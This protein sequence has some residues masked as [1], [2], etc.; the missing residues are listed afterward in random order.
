MLLRNKINNIL[1]AFVSLPLQAGKF[2]GNILVKRAHRERIAT[3]AQRLEGKELNKR[4]V[5]PLWQNLFF[6]RAL[7]ERIA[8][9]ARRLKEIKLNKRVVFPL[10]QNLFVKQARGERIA[11]KARRLKGEERYKRVVYLLLTGVVIISLFYFSLPDILFDSPTSVVIEDEKGNLL[12]AK[13]AADEQWR[14]PH[15]AD[16]PEKFRKALITYE[17]K[18]FYLHNGVDAPSVVRA[19]YQNLIRGKVFSGASTITM[20]TIRLS[21]QNKNRS[22][23]EKIIESVLALR[24]ELT[25]SKKEILALYS[26]NAPFGGNVVG[27]NAAA[28]RYFGRSPDKL[29]WAETATLAV[30]PNN[31]SLV[32]PGKNRSVLKSKRNFLLHELFSEGIID[33]L[34]YKLSLSEEVPVTPQKLPSL[35]PHLLD[36]VYT[37][38]A[39]KVKNKFTRV[40][41]TINSEFQIRANEIL[42]RHYQRLS[43]NGIYNASALI[44]DNHSGNVL[45]YTGNVGNPADK[46][47]GSS[48]DIITSRRSSGSILKPFLFAALMDEGSILPNS[49]IED[50]PTKFGG[51]RPLNFTNDY[52]GAVPAGETLA[53]SLN[54]PAVR[55]LQEY[56]VERFH[57]L[58]KKLG[59]NSLQYS[60]SH[61]GLSLILG[62]AEVT[63]WDIAGI[64]SAMARTL[65]HFHE[66]KEKH[67]RLNEFHPLN[68]ES[69]LKDSAYQ[70][71]ETENA[72]GLTAASVWF[73]FQAL[74]EA[75]RPSEEGSWLYFESSKTIAWKTGT[76]Q[77]FRD[78]WSVGCT[79]DFTVAV[80][81]GNADGE[82]R[83]L[84]TGVSAAA[85]I[86]FDLFDFLPVT[87]KW[88]DEPVEEMT[89]EEICVQSGYRAGENC[90]EKIR[91]LIPRTGLKSNPC[92]YH[93]IVHLEKT[94]QWRVNSSF[95]SPDDFV[96]KSWFVLPPRMEWFYKNKNSDYVT[97][98]P[99]HPLCIGDHNILSME[100]IYP[101]PNMK[102]FVPVELD[103]RTGGA[104]LE[105][106]HRDPRK[107][108]HWHL[109]EEYLGTTQIYHQIPVSP[110]PGK[111][112]LVLVDEDGERIERWFEIVK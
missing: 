100:L 78:A 77:G 58:L 62:G 105:A 71:E 94:E 57:F 67:Y 81:A 23:F 82:G 109:D 14:F 111:H 55:L 54:V 29:S 11:T 90:Q 99:Y 80:W 26:S 34:T 19:V 61:Y 37:E 42:D 44:I 1:R 48:V 97:L 64:Y 103:G 41:T 88:F 60:P 4:V 28:W 65:N 86:M 36:R 93:V 21:R 9:K 53:R 46:T 33:P 87:Q 25:Y 91:R 17:D 79:P 7:R 22:L 43:D 6:K 8:M 96:D 13:I 95:I 89:M 102:I 47:H 35:A 51:F 49:L 10:W 84:L 106:A 92:P 27:L 59:V 107:L 73:V 66:N 18:R 38:Q 39:P 50:V 74:T 101:Q 20:Q 108:I 5:F 70:F 76:S 68:F 3:K 16:V 32:H 2:V 30:L 85:P 83:P 52:D 98:P 45:A 110:A 104:V 75:N 56:G 15:N 69:V 72:P 112:K 24:L 12:G 31:P 40:V 63:L